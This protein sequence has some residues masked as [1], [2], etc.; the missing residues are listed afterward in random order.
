MDDVLISSHTVDK[1]LKY[2][3][4]FSGKDTCVKAE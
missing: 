2:G 4:A 1:I 3:I